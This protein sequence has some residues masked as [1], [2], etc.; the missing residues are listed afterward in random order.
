MDL[1]TKV[2]TAIGFTIL[3]IVAL[4]AAILVLYIV[5][6]VIAQTWKS[7]SKTVNGKDEKSDGE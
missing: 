1:L 4:I 7:A 3:I 2:A 6:V 5:F